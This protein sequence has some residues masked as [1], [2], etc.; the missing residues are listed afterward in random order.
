M[1][2]GEIQA[3]AKLLDEKVGGNWWER[4]DLQRLAMFNCYNCVL[5]Q[6]FG[7]YFDGLAHVEEVADRFDVSARFAREHGFSCVEHDGKSFDVLN[8]EWVAF[9]KGKQKKGE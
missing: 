2:E 1:F 3:G 9:L 4:I 8:E 7:E 5:G 6:L